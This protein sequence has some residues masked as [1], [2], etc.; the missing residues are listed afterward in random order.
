MVVHEGVGHPDRAADELGEH[1]QHALSRP[2]EVM[3][4]GTAGL[5]SWFRILNL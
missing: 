4:P 2:H 5:R 1:I 3:G